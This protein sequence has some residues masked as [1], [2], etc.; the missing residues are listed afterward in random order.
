[1]QRAQSIRIGFDMDDV[2]CDTHGALIHWAET[3][4]DLSLTDRRDQ[5]IHDLL[6]GSQA[7][8]MTEMLNE[9][10]FFR[11]LDP[12]QDAIQVLDKLNSKYDVFIVTAAMEHPACMSHKFRWISEYLPFFNPL[13]IVFC[14]EKYVADV[15]F[16]VDDTPRHFER[17][18]GEGIVFSAPKNLQEDRYRRVG[19]WD[20]VNKLFESL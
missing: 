1:M 19:S 7:K 18:R 11:N 4:F 12:L 2:I 8:Q 10:S 15:D 6:T 9:G 17:L 14:G 3:A 5:P 13:N 16:L 20:D